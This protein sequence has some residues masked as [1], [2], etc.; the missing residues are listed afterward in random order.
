MYWL[1]VAELFEDAGVYS[2]LTK[3]EEAYPGANILLFKEGKLPKVRHMFV[4]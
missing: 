4:I 1:V 3:L 2:R